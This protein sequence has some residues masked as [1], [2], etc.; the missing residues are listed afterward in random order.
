MPS[1]KIADVPKHLMT[2]GNWQNYIWEIC[3]LAVIVVYFGNFLYGKSKNYRL[4]HAWYQ[5]HR[6]LL[7]RHFAIV[8]DDGTSLD[9]TTSDKKKLDENGETSSS[10]QD[11]VEQG[12]L[13]KVGCNLKLKF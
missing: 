13:I 2:N 10:D 12:K 4:V 3:M 8:G 9:P 5:S 1:L 11:I 7:E 6:D